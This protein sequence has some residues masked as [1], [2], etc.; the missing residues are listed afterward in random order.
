[1]SPPCSANHYRVAHTERLRRTFHALTGRCLLDPALAPEAAAEALFHAPFVVLSH[2]ASPDPLLT[3]GNR[4]ALELFALSWEEL[5]RMPSRLTA[6]APDRAER[7]RLLAAVAD[8]G[9]IDDYSG[10]RISRAGRRFRIERATVWN[11]TDGAG[12]LCGQAATFREWRDL[13]GAE[14]GRR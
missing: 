7:A 5:V 1:M 6:K 8:R 14:E 13:K 3:Y 12:R 10:V 11:L 2:D 9:Y 4:A